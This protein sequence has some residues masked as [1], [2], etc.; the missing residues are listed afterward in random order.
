MKVT[1]HEGTTAMQPKPGAQHCAGASICA[2]YSRN[3]SRIEHVESGST[4]TRAKQI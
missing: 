1:R 2:C 4:P 3:L